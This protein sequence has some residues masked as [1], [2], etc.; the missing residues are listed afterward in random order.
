MSAWIAGSAAL[1]CFGDTLATFEALVHGRCGAGPLRHHDPEMVG[2]TRGY[3]IADRTPTLAAS[4]WLA[5]CVADALDQAGVDPS[6]QR[7]L[8]LVGTGLRELSAVE[9]A[10]TGGPACTAEQL[11][12]GRAVSDAAPGLRSVVT[13]ANA[14]SAGGHALALAQDLIELG[15]ADAVVVGGT[16]AMTAS[17]LAMIGRFGQSVGQQVRPFDDERCGVLLGDGA[18]ALVVVPERATPRPLAR[19]L[20]T[21]LSC[22]AHHETAPHDGGIM[23]AMRDAYERADR[24]PS[25]VDLVM[26]H[27]TGTALNDP[28]E[29]TLLRDLFA[30]CRP[31]PLVTAVKGSV[32]HTSGGSALLSIATALQCQRAGVVPAICGLRTPMAEADGLRLVVGAPARVTPHTVQVNS[33]GFGGVNA[34]TLLEGVER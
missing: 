27:G 20:A 26:A 19:L 9:R 25:D 2:V 4:G 3:E 29:V 22:D 28:T 33:F 16:D 18:A 30:D 13:L 15:D 23:A 11:H 10:A 21:G 32:G 17:M 1:T 5:G 14:C 31:G 34:V 6:R 8:A 7:V 12:F 24:T